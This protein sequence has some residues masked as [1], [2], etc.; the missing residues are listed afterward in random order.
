I[1]LPAMCAPM[2]GISG[3]AL[4]IA[5]C[6]AGIMAGLPRHNAASF[7]QFEQWLRE[8]RSA[9]DRHRD[10]TPA[11]PIGPLAVNLSGSTAPNEIRRELDLYRRYGV[12]IVISA[13]GDPTE[14]AKQ[15]HDWGGRIFHD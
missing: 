8:I 15:V 5:A 14:L 7:E 4:V 11:T 6:K 3:P 12:D 13:R 2:I 10:E 9:L 1:R